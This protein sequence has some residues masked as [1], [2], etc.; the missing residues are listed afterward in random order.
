VAQ[1]LEEITEL[2]RV[3]NATPTTVDNALTAAK[4]KLKAKNST[5]GLLAIIDQASDQIAAKDAQIEQLTT[6][7]RNELEQNKQREL[8]AKS[9]MASLDKK[10][11]ERDAKIDSL[12]EDFKNYQAQHQDDLQKLQASLDQAHE[13]L[14][15]KINL[16]TQEITAHQI[17]LKEKDKKIKLLDDRVRDLQKYEV[18]EGR[19][20]YPDGKVTQVVGKDV[21]Y[22]DIGSHNRAFEGLT[23]RV[24]AASGDAPDNTH[25][26]TLILKRVGEKS[27]ECQITEVKDAKDPV[28][29]G[30]LIASIA[31]DENQPHTFVV[32]GRFDLHGGTNPTEAGAKQLVAMIKRFGGEV[33]KQ[34]TVQTDFVVMGTEPQRP[35]KPEEDAP[36]TAW[37]TYNAQMQEYETYQ[38]V[39]EEALRM[40]IRILNTNR[41]LNL[42]G[43]VP[44]QTL[45]YG[46][47]KRGLPVRARAE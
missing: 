13:A 6:D 24:F 21:C 47:D 44:T 38:K 45:Q 9:R 20:D 18:A 30:D 26:A 10:L 37:A 33:A 46:Y 32:Q 40:G 35:V 8:A 43:Y 14:K 36:P 2:T 5:L 1:L 17:D 23:F 15:E 42:V 4:A 31:F 34:V 3:I 22:V 12:S 27:S 11:S 25:K 41:F 16:Q 29:A 28:V 7:L 19:V 39:K